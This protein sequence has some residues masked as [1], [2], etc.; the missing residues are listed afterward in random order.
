[1]NLD[2]DNDTDGPLRYD[3]APALIECGTFDGATRGE[4]IEVVGGKGRRSRHRTGAVILVHGGRPLA[5]DNLRALPVPAADV[6]VTPWSEHL[7]GQEI[8]ASPHDVAL[9]VVDD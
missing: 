6:D 2:P 1:M 3:M 7:L 5:W 4:A 8:D 9:T